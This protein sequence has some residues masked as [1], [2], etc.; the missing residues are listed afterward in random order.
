MYG[1]WF[2]PLFGIFC[3]VIFLYVFSKMFSGGG[4]CGKASAGSDREE[5]NEL[6]NEIYELRKEIKKLHET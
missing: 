3:M 5:I 4:F 2:M 1:W 6:K